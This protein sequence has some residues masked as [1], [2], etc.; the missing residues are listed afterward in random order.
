MVSS[1]NA[2]YK[3]MILP[4][5]KYCDYCI[6]NEVECCGIWGEDPYKSDGTLDTDVL[7]DVMRRTANAGIREKLIVHAKSLGICYDV[8]T[9]TFTVVPSLKIPPEKI[10]GS[11]GAGDAF[12]AGCLLGIYNGMQDAQILKFAAGAAACNLFA[13][14]STDGMRDKTEVEKIIKMYEV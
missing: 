10:M 13:Q 11:T 2:D 7:K 6:I 12:C 5:L 1:S 4:A 3:K 8:K 9:D 14:N